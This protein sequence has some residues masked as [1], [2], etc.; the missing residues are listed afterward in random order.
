MTRTAAQIRQEFMS[1]KE[2]IILQRAHQTCIQ[3]LQPL[4]S[5]K[6]PS[7]DDPNWCS[8]GLEPDPLPK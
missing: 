7:A 5:L 1:W 8:G 2:D 3:E 6:F 4:R